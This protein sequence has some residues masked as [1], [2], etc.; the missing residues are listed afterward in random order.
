MANEPQQDFYML[1]LKEVAERV[2]VSE[3]TVKRWLNKGLKAFRRGTVVR[4][5]TTDLDAFIAANTR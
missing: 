5:R 2:G 3:R 1:T 4:I